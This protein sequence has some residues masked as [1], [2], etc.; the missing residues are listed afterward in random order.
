ME[1]NEV[2]ESLQSIHK[3]LDSIEKMVSVVINSDNEVRVLDNQDMMER[4]RMSYKTLARY[5]NEGLLHPIFT[6][7]RGTK[8]LYTPEELDRFIREV[9]SVKTEK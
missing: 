2:L 8:N 6:D 1:I 5:R 4:L 7:K 9:L 3:R